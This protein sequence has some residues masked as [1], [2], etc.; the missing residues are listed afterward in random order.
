V[1]ALDL[2]LRAGERAAV[3][4]PNGSGKSTLVRLVAGLLRPT[5]GT[6]RV[7]GE[8]PSRAGVAFRRRTAVALDRPAHWEVLGA[9]ENALLLA[10]A[11]GL[12]RE[13]ARRRIDDL[14]S[15]FGL[16]AAADVPV[17]ELSLGM[18]RRLHL[19]EALTADV[20]LLVLDEP[21][22]G[23]DPEGVL[24]LAG[25]LGRR[26]ERGTAVLLAT[27]DVGAVPR[28]AGRVVFLAAGRV[29][30]DDAPAALLA[31]LGGRT[32]L[33]VTLAA[34][35]RS[36]AELVRDPPPAPGVVL[37]ESEGRLVAESDGGTE[38][39]PD[40]L[41]ALLDRGATVQGVGVR[42]PDL[43]DVFLEL[44]GRPLGSPV[45]ERPSGATGG[46]SP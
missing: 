36:A 9:R 32:R 21:T 45:P 6:L 15:R 5:G 46:A 38:P 26:A 22:L 39:L 12:V 20:E 25:E 33:E 29:L 35:G 19:V 18:R 2:E 44:A 3:V 24:A 40:L 7:L 10:S 28:L 34:T 30:A 4:G 17:G 11:R 8:D 42:E 41:R 27:N 13:D 1:R 16:T 43:G 31:R 14:L 23:L 37:R